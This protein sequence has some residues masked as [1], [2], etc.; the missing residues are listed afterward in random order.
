MWDIQN[1]T[2][3][4]TG[5]SSGI[6]NHLASMFAGFGALV[7]IGARRVDQLEELFQLHPTSIIP[8]GLDI[9]QEQSVQE[10]YERIEQK[11]L[12]P[13]VLINN[14]G[15]LDGGGSFTAMQ[16]EVFQNSMSTNITGTWLMSKEFV[17]R[18]ATGSIINVASILGVRQQAGT[19]AYST[20]K[21]AVIQMTKLMALEAAPTHR[22]NAIAAGYIATPDIQAM[23]DSY[24]E[25]GK[26]F[27]NS[28]PLRRFGEYSDLEGPMML[29]ATGASR[30]MTGSVIEVDGG[31]LVKSL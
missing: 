18:T 26:A 19:F 21:A 4:I 14:A 8:L 9:T 2:I 5:A 31:H 11:A 22:V 10:F 16:T 7:V 1:Q 13:T 25:Y 28:I 17:N 27:I 23:F 3:I 15:V 29:L 20:T 24:G 12:T 6:G 30:Y